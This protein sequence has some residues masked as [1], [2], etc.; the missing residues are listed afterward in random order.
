MTEYSFQSFFPL[1]PYE[2][3]MAGRKVTTDLPRYHTRQQSPNNDVPSTSHQQTTLRNLRQTLNHTTSIPFLSTN[4]SFAI[5]YHRAE[6][7]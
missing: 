3:K 5:S 4:L 1:F 7:I 2:P 6:E